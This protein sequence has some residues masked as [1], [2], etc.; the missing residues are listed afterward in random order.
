MF[1]PLP[2]SLGALEQAG[3]LVNDVAALL[4]SKRYPTAAAIALFAREEIGRHRIILDFWRRSIGGACIT[5]EQVKN[6]CEDNHFAK[7]RR[8]SGVLTSVMTVTVMLTAVVASFA[9][10]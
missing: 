2:G 1:R 4:E 9:A 10:Q 6:A 5:T 8:G 3:I 7:Q